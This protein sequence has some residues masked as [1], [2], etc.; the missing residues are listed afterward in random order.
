MLYFQKYTY[1][2]I[3]CP[4]VEFLKYCAPCSTLTFVICQKF[5]WGVQDFP[6]G[7]ANL[8]GRGTKSLLGES[9]AENCMKIKEIGPRGGHASLT[10]LLNVLLVSNLVVMCGHY[11]VWGQWL[12]E[13]KNL[14][15]FTTSYK[16]CERTN[17]IDQFIWNFALQWNLWLYDSCWWRCLWVVAAFLLC[18]KYFV[19][20]IYYQIEIFPMAQS[21]VKFRQ[22]MCFCYKLICKTKFHMT[23]LNFPTK[24]PHWN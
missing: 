6:E 7:N 19:R 16:A 20:C 15:H 17:Q 14:S 3:V 4:A 23:S 10:P 12:L 9:F 2:R 1:V 13:H 11:L 8:R 22:S 24:F 18:R 5:Q 21:T